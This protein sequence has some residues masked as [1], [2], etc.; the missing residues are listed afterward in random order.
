VYFLRDARHPNV[1]T[2]A[3]DEQRVKHAQVRRSI[4]DH[5]RSTREPGVGTSGSADEEDA[6]YI[7]NG[8]TLHEAA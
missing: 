1:K 7:V 4:G 8:L 2:I 6:A 3:A 5:G